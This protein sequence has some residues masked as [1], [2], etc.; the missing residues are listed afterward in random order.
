ML[1][2]RIT[3]TEN[4]WNTSGRFNRKRQWRRKLVGST[5]KLVT[6]VRYTGDRKGLPQK[7][8]RKGGEKQ[9]Q[10]RNEWRKIGTDQDQDRKCNKQQHFIE[11]AGGC[12]EGTSE[13]RSTRIGEMPTLK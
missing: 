10:G 1:G 8:R 3:M 6:K 7:S 2:A 5:K 11:E 13:I 4:R 12:K 9:G